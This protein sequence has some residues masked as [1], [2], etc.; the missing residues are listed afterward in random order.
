MTEKGNTNVPKSITQTIAS[1][2]RNSITFWA[3]VSVPSRRRCSPGPRSRALYS[4]VRERRLSRSN[5]GPTTADT[6]PSRA[7]LG[8]NMDFGR[9]YMIL[10]KSELSSGGGR[11]IGSGATAQ[12]ISC[13]RRRTG[14]DIIWERSMYARETKREKS[15]VT[16]WGQH[17]FACRA[18]RTK[19]VKCQWWWRGVRELVVISCTGT[20]ARAIEG[21]DPGRH[22]TRGDTTAPPWASSCLISTSPSFVL[23]LWMLRNEQK[24]RSFSSLWFTL[25][26][27]LY[28]ENPLFI[29]FQFTPIAVHYSMSVSVSLSSDNYGPLYEHPETCLDHESCQ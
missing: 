18:R 10:R 8:I 5:T 7:N 20:W 22:G 16:C 17:Y 27:F 6:W 11:S 28:A 29:F 24:A 1:D 13:G 12:V 23:H 9:M 2:A 19:R 25:A 3:T 26:P 21:E 15:W 14:I 4:D